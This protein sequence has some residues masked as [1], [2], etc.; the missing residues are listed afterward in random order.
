MRRV[1]MAVLC[2]ALVLV[3][4][5]ALAQSSERGVMTRPAQDVGPTFLYEL[6]GSYNQA[7]EGYLGPDTL[8]TS[9]GTPILFTTSPTRAQVTDARFGANNDECVFLDY[10][11]LGDPVTVTIF[12]QTITPTATTDRIEMEYNAQTGI[13]AGTAL[14]GVAMDC[15]VF[16]GGNS[17]PCPGTIFKPF[18]VRRDR[19]SFDGNL[20][21]ASY[22]ATVATDDTSNS[23]RV[24][25]RMEVA[26][27]LGTRV[28][29]CEAYLA[30]D[31]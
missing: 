24:L 13:N 8:T 3:A 28:S 7:G 26:P 10:L 27:V 14:N 5:P 20:G 17:V 9:S 11:A 1:M 22:H 25:I 21:M 19:T 16:Q 6:T 12:D 31:W 18:M 15:T 23:I 29:V 4:A 2:V 30:L